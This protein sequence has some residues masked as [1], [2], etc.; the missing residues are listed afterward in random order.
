MAPNMNGIGTKTEGRLNFEILL[1]A[2]L[3]LSLFPLFTRLAF[4]GAA[5]LSLHFLILI[6]PLR[7]SDL[8][9]A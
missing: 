5:P 8:N 9:P 6:R 1:I 3:R 2:S 7:E 4:A